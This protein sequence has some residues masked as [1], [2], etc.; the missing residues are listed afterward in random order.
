MSNP[1]TPKPTPEALRRRIPDIK[2]LA[3]V[4][5]FKAPTLDFKKRRLQEAHTV[6]DLRSIAKRRTPKAPFDYTDG[7]NCTLLNNS[8]APVMLISPSAAPSV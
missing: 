8:R 6:W 7:T 4:M 5:K 1:H 3:E 2:T